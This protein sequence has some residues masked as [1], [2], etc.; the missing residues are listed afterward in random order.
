MTKAIEKLIRRETEKALLVEVVTGR[1]NHAQVWLPKSQVAIKGRVIEIAD[2][3]LAK[4]AAE[5]GGIITLD[6][7]VAAQLAA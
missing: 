2:W 6:V 7:S 3:L 4:K 1:G 5:I